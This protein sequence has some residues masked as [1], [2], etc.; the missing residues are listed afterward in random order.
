DGDGQLLPGAVLVPARRPPGEADPR[1]D[2]AGLG[3]ARPLPERRPV[4]GAGALGAEHP[5]RAPRGQQ[6]LG[7]ER[8]AGARQRAADR[9]PE[10]VR[11]E[12]RETPGKQEVSA[13]C[14]RR[15]GT[16]PPS[17]G[18]PAAPA[19]AGASRGSTRGTRRGR[20]PSAA[21]RRRGSGA[22]GTGSSP[23]P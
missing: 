7:P 18:G 12:T 11:G 14:P 9:V 13:S 8:L 22:P 15:A 21:A 4:A 5:R 6:P 20:R 23:A 16:P 19:S 2:A 1:A 17:A 3:R 10:G